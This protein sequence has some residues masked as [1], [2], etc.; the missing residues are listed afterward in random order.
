MMKETLRNV[1]RMLRKITYGAMFPLVIL[2]VASGCSPEPESVGNAA[3]EFRE[4]MQTRLNMYSAALAEALANHQ[5]KQVTSVLQRLHTVSTPLEADLPSFLSVLDNHG[6]TVANWAGAAVDRTRNYGRYHIV[7]RVIEKK[8]PLQSALYL[9]EG[10]KV[11]IICSPL[12]KREKVVGVLIIG[13]SDEQL[14]LAGISEKEFMSL[15]FS[16]GA[17]GRP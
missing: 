11:Y 3:L 9:Q 13:I 14:K 4:K 1:S 12:L 16:A 10:N 2:T 5:R 6:V 17:E 7:S 15:S 8:K